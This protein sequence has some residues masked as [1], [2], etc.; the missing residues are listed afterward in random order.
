VID[1]DAPDEPDYTLIP[2]EELHA[3][4]ARISVEVQLREHELAIECLR[5]W[6]ANPERLAA[7]TKHYKG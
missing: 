4:A 6:L 1:W 3:E 7:I 2:I 5:W